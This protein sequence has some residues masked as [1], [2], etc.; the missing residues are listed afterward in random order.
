MRSV[1]LIGK[2][3][4]GAGSSSYTTKAA[5]LGRCLRAT[6]TYIDNIENPEDEA[7]TPVDESRDVAMMY[8]ERAVQAT[9]PANSAPTFLDLDPNTEGKQNDAATR[10]I[11]ENTDP[12]MPI[13]DAIGAEDSNSDLLIHTLGGADADS[14][15]IDRKTGQL[16]TKAELNYEMKSTYMVMVTA[17]DP[18]GLQCQRVPVTINV[19]DKDDPAEIAGEKEFDYEENDDSRV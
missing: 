3:L 5:D 14:F 9:N 13:G 15:A 6:A 19:N 2:P 12:E 18:S 16:M 10:G 1:P 7:G 8:T 11:D 17:T 4:S